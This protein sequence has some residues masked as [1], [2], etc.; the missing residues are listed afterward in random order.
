MA[1][2]FTC[3]TLNN[4]AAAGATSQVIVL[5]Q[6][7]GQSLDAW[8]TAASEGW[9]T[10]T[11]ASG[12]GAGAIIVSVN[13][14]TTG[15]ARNAAIIVTDTVSGEVGA[16][17]V[18]QE[19]AASPA[20]QPLAAN[21]INPYRGWLVIAA[22][23]ILILLSVIG[24]G[25]YK[26][27]PDSPSSDSGVSESQTEAVV[28]SEPSTFDSGPLPTASTATT[29]IVTTTKEDAPTKIISI[30]GFSCGSDGE[31]FDQLSPVVAGEF[32]EVQ[33]GSVG[34]YAFFACDYSGNRSPLKIKKAYVSGTDD[35]LIKHTENRITMRYPMG[36]DI[37]RAT[38]SVEFVDLDIIFTF[39]RGV[40]ITPDVDWNVDDINH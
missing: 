33:E 36:M 19:A 2:N 16:V 7:P 10:L 17:T 37:R 8:S 22:V 15:S 39:Y 11:P 5:S 21:N 28:T 13:D 9:V 23:A 35:I 38:I 31:V 40:F 4:F 25:V 6:V 12:T 32:S 20:L 26:G 34:Y 30:Q 18:H 1:T 3:S 14:N 24:Y 27:Y 29:E